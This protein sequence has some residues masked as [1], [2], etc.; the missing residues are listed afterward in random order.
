MVSGTERV[1]R[2]RIRSARKVGR[3]AQRRIIRV[4]SEG[5]V[6]E[7]EYLSAVAGRDVTL[8]FGPT[9][10]PL[11]LLQQARQEVDDNR[12]KRA[13]ERFDEIWCVFDR[14]EHQ[15]FDRVVAE[16][17]Q[18]PAFGG[19]PAGLAWHTRRPH[20]RVFPPVLDRVG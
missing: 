16:A 12:R 3:R 10:D 19:N 1:R 18:D 8:S 15:H 4:L 14:D 20:A 11:F 7:S 17:G 9:G 2:R 6:T 13:D 5:E